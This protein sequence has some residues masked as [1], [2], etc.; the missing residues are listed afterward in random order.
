MSK[1][2]ISLSDLPIVTVLVL[3]YNGVEHL[4]GCFS[5]L[6]AVDYP[7]DRLELML[8]D[9]A[10]TDDSVEYM[11]THYPQVRIVYSRE[12][13]GFGS[14]NNLGVR[15]ASGK[16]VVLLNNDMWVD[17]RIVRGLL[18]AIQSETDAVCAGAKILNW[19]GTEFDYAGSAADF[20][21]HAYQVAWRKPYS[22]DRFTQVHSTLFACGGAMMVDRQ[23]F[24]EVGGFDDDF[25]IYYEDLDFGWRLWVLGYRVVFAPEAVA[26]HRHH[27]TMDSYSDHRK[28]VLYKRN[29]L[30]SMFKNYEDGNLERVLSA[31]LL[32]TMDGMVQRAIQHGQL[33]LDEYYI[34]AQQQSSSPP[35]I[36]KR[37]MATFV[38][39]HDVVEHLPQV[40]E[41]RRFI[42]QKR[43]RSDKEIAQLFRWPFRAWPDADLR[44]QYPIAEGLGVQSLFEDVPRRV[45]II[46]SDILPY[47]GMPT[48]G[49]GLRAW[50]LG[51]GLKSRGHEVL[52]A[53]PRAALVGREEIAPPETVELAWEPQTL[54]SVVVRAEP[55]VVVVCNWPVMDLLPTE[56]LDMPLILDQHGPH[57]LEREYQK[58]GETNDNARRKIN[59]LRKADFFTCAG[60][61]QLGY[62]QSWL[63]RAGWTELERRERA[64]FIPVSLSPDLPEHAPS[65]ELKFVYGGV[66][67][68]WQDPSNALLALVEILNRRKEGKLYFYG[69]K[70]PVYPVDPGIFGSLVEKLKTSPHVLVPGMVSHDELIAQYVRSHVAIDVMS[71]NPEREL[72]FTTRTV[73]YLWCGL[74]IVYHDY[75][76]L[77]DFI[78]EYNAGWIVDPENRA[79][80]T[81]IL[82]EIFEHPEQLAERSRNAQR[83]VR[84]KLTWDRTIDPMDRF[85]RHPNH[86]GQRAVER[87]T[88]ESRARSLVERARFKYQNGGLRT[89]TRAGLKFIQRRLSD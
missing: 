83:L 5:S 30:Y 44:I 59:A 55:D 10:S 33:N 12:N 71:R 1:T 11:R 27:G 28:W 75:A 48:V 63:E 70:H 76:E 50:G 79:A 61:K 32:A 74:P 45:L 14:G 34:K 49:S 54:A 68:P 31:T 56:L 36:G 2:A 3:N 47:S 19:N 37:D 66:F 58:F 77:S 29:A 18:E 81:G 26:Y 25:F 82:D 41:K 4:K 23:V 22:P 60:E 57:Y 67:L 42:Q 39:I 69:G 46:S 64:A 53:M 38:A 43:R 89:L 62:F 21:A 15:E 13:V 80:I 78:R 85:I 6:T 40:I 84:E 88:V 52:F 35:S 87:G 17:P 20:A 24:L 72:A 65:G 73:E 86:R 9:N 51:Q 7:A 16:Y 8:V